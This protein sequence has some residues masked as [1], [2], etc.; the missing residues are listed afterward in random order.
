MEK[1]KVGSK[2]V[3]ARRLAKE[4]SE[5]ELAAIGGRGTSYSGTGGCVEG[6]GADVAAVDSCDGFDRFAC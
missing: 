5:A 4:L 1:Q 3:L 6:R 2:R